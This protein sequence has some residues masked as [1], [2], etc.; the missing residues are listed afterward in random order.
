MYLIGFWP[1][2][3]RMTSGWVATKV[4]NSMTLRSCRGTGVKKD[5]FTKNISTHLHYVAESRDSCILRSVVLSTKAVNHRS[6]RGHLGSQGQKRGQIQT[7]F[8]KT[9]S[10]SNNFKW[11]KWQCQCV[12]VGQTCISVH[13]D[14][15]VR[16]TVKGS[17]VKEKSNY[18]MC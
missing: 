10:N 11:Q 2:L 9:R 3:V 16:P 15:F 6:I 17:K 1:N 4:I 5:I 7:T 14:L 12:G 8:Q 13:D 18:K